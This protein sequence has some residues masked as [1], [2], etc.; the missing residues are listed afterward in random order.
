LRI[1]KASVVVISGEITRKCS[2]GF[3]SVLR[4]DEIKAKMVKY[5]K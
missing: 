3:V 5:R 2:I 1:V 4:D